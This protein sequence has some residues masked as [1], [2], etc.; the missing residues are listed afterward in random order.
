[1]RRKEIEAAIKEN[2]GMLPRHESWRHAYFRDPY[3]IRTSKEDLFNRT[4]DVFHNIAELDG[5]GKIA[6]TAGMMNDAWLMQK[7]THLI[8]EYG[9]RGGVPVDLIS[10]ANE[11][12]DKYFADGEPVGVRLFRNL[13]QP[14][15][16]NL[17]RFS[18]RK[19]LED[20]FHNGRIMVSPASSY[21]NGS[22]LNAQKDLETTR[23]YTI[24]THNFLLNG[25]THVNIEGKV[26]DARAGDVEIVENVPDYYAYC[27][28]SEIDRRL[29]S[30]FKADAALVISDPKRFQRLFFD[31]LRSKLKGWEMRRGKVKYYDPFLDYKKYSD[32]E[33]TKHF[34]YH[35]QKEFRLVA[36]PKRNV[37]QTLE[38]FFINVG[39]MTEYSVLYTLDGE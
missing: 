16:S 2:K 21:S 18:R 26:Y 9:G 37:G 39:P 32:L 15:G 4:C 22:L 6:P 28:C 19:Y 20:M 33:M 23:S 35:Y 13:E 11:P 14:K 10:A 17:V 8:E 12:L 36:R 3:L 25:Q 7:F 24:P 34:R 5:L 27:M 1:M 30:D 38:P 31:S 29:P